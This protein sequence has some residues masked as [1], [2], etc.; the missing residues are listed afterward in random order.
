MWCINIFIIVIHNIF[1]INIMYIMMWSISWISWSWFGFICRFWKMW[2]I[3]QIF[4]YNTYL[5]RWIFFWFLIK[6]NFTST[7]FSKIINLFCKIQIRIIW[8]PWLISLLW[9]LSKFKFPRSLLNKIFRSTC[10]S[11]MN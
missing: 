7:L 3:S 8:F 6:F 5:Q 4:W 1:I 11:K 10:L 2:I 9:Y